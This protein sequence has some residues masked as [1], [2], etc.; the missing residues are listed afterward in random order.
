MRKGRIIVYGAKYRIG[1]LVLIGFCLMRNRNNVYEIVK[2]VMNEANVEK[3][4]TTPCNRHIS[5]VIYIS[6]EMN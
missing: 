4:F 2:D 3:S 6:G 1:F 5:G